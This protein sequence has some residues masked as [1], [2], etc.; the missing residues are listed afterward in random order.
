[1]PDFA[2]QDYA[3]TQWAAEHIQPIADALY[4][5]EL[6]EARRLRREA[7]VALEQDTQLPEDVA[8]ALGYKL[9]FVHYNLEWYPPSDKWT[10]DNYRS[11]MELFGQPALT[12]FGDLQRLRGLLVMHFHASRDRFEPLTHEMMMG[13]VDQLQGYPDSEVWF[14]VAGWAFER[15]DLALLERAFEHELTD[16]ARMMG[17]AKWQ[18]INMMYQ[19][20]AGK[21]ARIDVEQT[22]RSLEILPQLNEFNTVIWPRCVEAGITDDELETMLAERSAHIEASR[23]TAR[24]EQRTKRVRRD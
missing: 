15:G 20:V 19:L 16:P 12:R 22:V 5:E 17:H 21:A 10:P 14:Y 2:A 3:F 24:R 23:P 6:D 8:E 1:M 4:R 13:Y 18:R 7:S 11:A 9:L